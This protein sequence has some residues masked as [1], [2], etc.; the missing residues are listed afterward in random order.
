MPGADYNIAATTYQTIIRES[1]KSSERELVLARWGLVPFF[2]K[3]LSDNEEW[4][5]SNCI[6]YPRPANAAVDG[7]RAQS[8]TGACINIVFTSPRL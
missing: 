8:R 7:A 5:H 3:E 4:E 6:D 1:R 2:T